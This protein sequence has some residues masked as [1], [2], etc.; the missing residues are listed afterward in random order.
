MKTIGTFEA[1]THFSR[2]LADV[3]AGEAYT[4][5]RN[6]Q[7]VAEIHPI[8]VPDRDRLDEAIHLLREVRARAKPDPGGCTIR[9]LIESSRRF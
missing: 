5:T 7:P 4:I 1:K 3:A 8:R 2:L 6:G 9:E